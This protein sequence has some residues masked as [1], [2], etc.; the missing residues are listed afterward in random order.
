MPPKKQPQKR[1]QKQNQHEKKITEKD[2]KTPPRTHPNI[3]K[4]SSPTQN[5]PNIN[6]PSDTISPS[7][8]PTATYSQIASTPPPIFRHTMPKNTPPSEPP[9]K[10][11]NNSGSPMK[12]EAIT[13]KPAIKL[14]S[15]LTKNT[16]FT[17]NRSEPIITFADT[18]LIAPTKPILH[19]DHNK[20][21]H[22]DFFR[23]T[24]QIGMQELIKYS[25]D[26]EHIS[27]QAFRKKS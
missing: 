13:L 4:P 18:T 27:S 12:T 24:G 25:F 8:Q 14:H 5:T 2:Q 19:Y 10:R 20:P 16:T 7:P 23:I 26:T 6:A 17:T 15:T 1:P 11:H 21:L 3:P 9:H 22:S